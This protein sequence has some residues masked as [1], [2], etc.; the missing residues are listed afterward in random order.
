MLNYQ[1]VLI[2]FPLLKVKSPR[3]GCTPDTNKMPGLSE[4]RVPQKMVS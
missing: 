3:F 4:T 2:I 1:R